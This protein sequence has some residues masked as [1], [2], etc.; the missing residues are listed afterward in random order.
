MNIKHISNI[1]KKSREWGTL[2]TRSLAQTLLAG[3]LSVTLI[4]RNS[5]QIDTAE[6]FGSKVYF[7]DGTRMDLLR[8]AGAAEAQLIMFCMDEVPEREFVD[9]VAE[10]FP[11]ATIY[12]R[13][14]DRKSVIALANSK[15]E[16]V[17][18]EVHESA[19]VVAR[20]ALANLGLSEREIEDAE[21]TYRENDRKRMGV[22]IEGGDIYA[23]REM[24]RQQQREL[25]GKS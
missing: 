9:A 10:A 13:G 24:T 11:K 18:R 16:Y 21:G 15:A 4:D 17:M 2:A 14:F 22:Q 12:V 3:G 20:M 8:Q 7:G 19:I 1:T 6:D 23:A 25:R 5:A